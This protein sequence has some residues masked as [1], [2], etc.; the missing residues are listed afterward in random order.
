MN[1]AKYH[2]ALTHTYNCFRPYKNDLKALMLA[3]IFLTMSG[4]VLSQSLQSERLSD[5]VRYNDSLGEAQGS[6]FNV[7]PFSGKP[8]FSMP[9][10]NVSGRGEAGFTFNLSREGEW[11]VS[12]DRTL[13][14][15]EYGNPVYT[16][17]NG[18]QEPVYEPTWQPAF[19]GLEER[20][21]LYKAT[22]Y[23]SG[24]GRIQLGEETYGSLDRYSTKIVFTTAS[25]S[26]HEFVDEL[27][28]GRPTPFV[29]GGLFNEYTNR[30]RVFKT[31]D[32]SMMT[33]VSDIDIRDLISIQT[34]WC[35]HTCTYFPFSGFIYTKDGTRMRVD[36]I[37]FPPYGVRQS[38]ITWIEDRNGN[39]TTFEYNAEGGIHQ[40]KLKRVIDSIGRVYTIDYSVD[41][42]APYGVSDK[43]TYR[44]VGGQI[45]V[46]R[47]SH[48]TLDEPE[49]LRNDSVIRMYSQLFNGFRIGQPFSCGYIPADGPVKPELRSAVWLPDGRAYKF[50]YDS[51]MIAM[52]VYQGWNCQPAGR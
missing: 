36:S 34:I 51:Y 48:K 23:A 6:L 11:L 39:R 28:D 37:V 27:T 4:Q 29:E 21:G 1:L 38:K 46:I 35:H 3:V 16:Y 12:G 43:I 25:G 50:Q 19:S 20:N 8:G 14:C 30:G 2:L 44:G 31:T 41:E 40:T 9:L 24:P 17:N 49:M 15:D 33:F 10:L 32:G 47:I 52:P 18:Y 5:A 7:N 45:R 26:T 22:G 13:V 42:G